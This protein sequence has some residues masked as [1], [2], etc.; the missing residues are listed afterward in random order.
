VALVILL[1][2]AY[3]ALRIFPAGFAAIERARQE[4]LAARLADQE[5][6]RWR[7]AAGSLPE[8]IVWAD[9]SGGSL[10]YNVNYGAYDPAD[11]LVGLRPNWD[12]PNWQPDSLYRPRTI[13]GEVLPIGEHPD[14]ATGVI[15]MPLCRLRFGP[16]AH[17]YDAPYD[18][19]DDY[20]QHFPL[21]IYTTQYDRVGNPNVLDPAKD[22]GRYFISSEYVNSAVTPAVDYAGG[23][24][25]FDRAPYARVFRVEFTYLTRVGAQEKRRHYEM[26]DLVTLITVFANEDTV[27]YPKSLWPER[28]GTPPADFATLV[29]ASE[30]VHQAFIFDGAA[31]PSGPGHF[32]LDKDISAPDCNLLFDRGDAGRTVHVDYRVRDWQ[33]LLEE[34]VPDESL[35]LQLVLTPLKSPQYRNPPRQPN[36]PDRLIPG[37]DAMVIVLD[38]DDG[39]RL[40]GF[41]AD[42]GTGLVDLRGATRPDGVAA[43]AGKTY[44]IYYRSQLDWA[45][46]PMKAAA[47]Y[48]VL[49]GDT[50]VPTYRSAVWV[51]NNGAPTNHLRFGRAEV[52]KSIVANYYM[53]ANPASESDPR[54]RLVAGELEQVMAVD[55]QGMVS[56]SQV[57]RYGLRVSGASLSARVLWAGRGGVQAS[58][59]GSPPAGT[60]GLSPES[61]RQ[62]KVE[63]F[64][65]RQ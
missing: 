23:K 28:F 8:A 62:I 47:E 52:A 33:I 20:P 41:T 60:R 29:P 9:S 56:L 46:Q 57:P 64:L 48:S 12:N 17:L 4:S 16:L 35:Q 49:L 38:T 32:A 31:A 18:N 58:G 43:A 24:I 59:A 50:Q 27:A 51:W 44:R 65:R 30:R 7:L 61:W 10:I 53:Y 22:W 21:F 34:R 42:Y 25:S 45:I 37:D 63:T 40:S 6:Q 39:A 19:R 11:P 55:D 5:I 14:P 13:I 1:V 54:P 36:A 2:G 3:V 26:L 15:S